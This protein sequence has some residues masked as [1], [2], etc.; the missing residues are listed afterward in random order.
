MGRQLVGRHRSLGIPR[1]G[2]LGCSKPK[3]WVDGH[4]PRSSMPSTGSSL[5][6]RGRRELQGLD[7]VR[8]DL[9]AVSHCIL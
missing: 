6:C 2:A 8:F 1:G 9:L 4:Q 7:L 5:M 3:V